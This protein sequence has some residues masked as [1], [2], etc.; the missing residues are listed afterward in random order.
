MLP[1]QYLPD[2]ALDFSSSLPLSIYLLCCHGGPK[3]QSSNDNKEIS[4]QEDPLIPLPVSSSPK[5]PLL[6]PRQ[7]RTPPPIRPVNL[8]AAVLCHLC[9]YIIH[10]FLSLLLSSITHLHLSVLCWNFYPCQ[11]PHISS[12]ALSSHLS[13]PLPLYLHHTI[14]SDSLW[15]PSLSVISVVSPPSDTDSTVLVSLPLTVPIILSSIP[16]LHVFSFSGA[17][18]CHTRSHTPANRHIRRPAY[19]MLPSRCPVSPPLLFPYYPISIIVVLI[20]SHLWRRTRPPLFL[21]ISLVY[22]LC[23][24]ASLPPPLSFSW[25]CTKVLITFSSIALLP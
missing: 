23:Y 20:V 1:F 24:P 8:S 14:I 6:I 17:G 10:P 2:P 5:P 3:T 11:K 18:R 12:A 13:L 4:R 15:C 21:L 16:Q 25:Y 22:F 19:L 7:P 9:L